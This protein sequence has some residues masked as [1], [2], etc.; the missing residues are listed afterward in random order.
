MG[1][2]HRNTVLAALTIILVTLAR[3]ADGH[4]G[5][6][7]IRSIE[8]LTLRN[9]LLTSGRRVAPVPQL[10]CRGSSCHRA[11]TTVRCT[12]AGWDG[13]DVTWD[14]KA[15]LDRSVK[16]GTLNVQC[17]G[18][19]HPEDAS[20][21]PGSCGLEYTLEPT[22]RPSADGHH[23]MSHSYDLP[24]HSS[25]GGLDWLGWLVPL[26]FVFML[27]SACFGNGRSRGYVH[28]GYYSH[29]GYGC[30]SYFPS[31][32]YGSSGPGFWT[33][34]AAGAL[35]ASAFSNRGYGSSYSGGSWG[36]GYGS[37]GGGTHTSTGFASTS[38]R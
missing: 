28:D 11:P 34:A 14:C 9:G 10:T 24:R 27:M 8:S 23:H 18:Y 4:Q 35:G 29:G 37:R 17:E 36:G 31:Y 15:E 25:G 30:G 13:S 32:G 21:L 12:N 38:R 26:F 7:P 19:A 20:I 3:A 6:V 22:G 33:G 1:N 16:F 2:I 5:G